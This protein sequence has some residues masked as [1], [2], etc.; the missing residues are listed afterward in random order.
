LLLGAPET[1]DRPMRCGGAS[2]PTPRE[3][4]LAYDW[5]ARLWLIDNVG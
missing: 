4:Q 3:I 2:P 5:D 1:P